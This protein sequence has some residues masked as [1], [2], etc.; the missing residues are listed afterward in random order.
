VLFASRSIIDASADSKTSGDSYT[1]T[2]FV[3]TG[4]KPSSS[5]PLGNPAYPGYTTAGGPH[6]LDDVISVYN[7]SLLLSYNFAYGGA[8]TD[9]TLVIPYTSTV[10]SF[11]DQVTIFSDNLAAK[12]SY[13]P[14]TSSNTLFAVWIGVNDVGNAWYASNWATLAPQIVA[15]YF[16]QVQILYNAGAR[17]FVFLSVPPIQRTPLDLTDTAADQASIAA[18]VV[19][20]NNLIA[21]N[22]ATFK[23]SNSEVKAW[24]YD[25][26]PPFNT[27]LDNPTA[28]GAPDNTCVNADGLSCLWYN[29]YH[30]GQKIHDLVAKG[31]QALVGS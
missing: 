23:S 15:R 11:V 9:A 12:P 10:Q 22:L 21:N 31:V 18:A 6:W 28:Y 19:T 20:Y 5:N 30:P 26:A 24:I 1:Q 27:V 2:G 7:H 4:G 17:N 14:W 3:I 29:N 16:S 8:T 25:T 13:A